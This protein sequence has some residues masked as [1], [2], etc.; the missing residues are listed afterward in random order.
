[1]TRNKDF[2]NI[3]S[4][5]R[6]NQCCIKMHQDYLNRISAYYGITGKDLSRFAWAEDR[7]VN[8]YFLE[9]FVDLI[10][11]ITSKGCIVFAE[12]N[13]S[14]CCDKLFHM[15][16]IE[17]TSNHNFG[18]IS[19][20]KINKKLAWL[21]QHGFI[22]RNLINNIITASLYFTYGDINRKYILNELRKEWVKKWVDKEYTVTQK[23]LQKKNILETFPTS[24]QKFFVDRYHFDEMLKTL[25][26]NQFT[27]EFNQCLFAYEH[28]KWFL[29]AAGLGSCLEHLMEKVIINYNKNGYPL[30]K[31]LGKDPTL[32]DYL[33]IFRKEPIN[34]EPRQETYIKML[35]M[36]RNSVDHHN[37]GYTSK[38][39]CD[40]LLDG[41]RN[42]FN[43]YY[44]QSILSKNNSK[45][46]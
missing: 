21:A 23:I 46:D 30:L 29:C 1:M 9:V 19:P 12:I 26:D 32:R 13:R 14:S 43:D 42:I 44:S 11:D 27:D 17:E 39:I 31:R 37:T 36:A 6:Y 41:I 22:S 28:E 40:S 8:L 16:L 35:F 20:V 45:G 4:L 10:N 34:L 15:N 24:S 7:N 25:D 18:E 5:D 2:N 33:N 38:N 3:T